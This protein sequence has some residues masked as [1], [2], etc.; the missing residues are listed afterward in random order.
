MRKLIRDGG[1]SHGARELRI[2]L[3]EELAALPDNDSRHLAETLRNE[4]R[5][6]EPTT[7]DAPTRQGI[8]VV[9]GHDSELKETVA[10]LL[11]KITDDPVTIL[12]EQPD[13]GQTV[14]EKFERHARTASFAVVLLTPDD[15]VHSSEGAQ[16]ARAR[17]NVILELG[18]FI[19]QLGRSR[20]CALY[21]VG[22][23]LPSDINGVLYKQVDMAGM[24]RTELAKELSAA[25]IKV[26]WDRL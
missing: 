3:I 14:I 19:G 15:V 16:E 1:A 24:W 5:L 25:D 18:Y 11:E 13:Q 20:V 7:S 26:R 23:A 21:K 10:R 22:V 9:H 17:Q 2:A 12:H 6:S 4:Q 8:F